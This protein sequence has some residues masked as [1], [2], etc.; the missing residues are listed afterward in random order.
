MKS[1]I[2]F[3]PL[4]FLIVIACDISK[5]Q[6]AQNL[7]ETF[8]TEE[9]KQLEFIEQK[10]HSYLKSQFNCSNEDC[11]NQYL[12]SL[13]P[14]EKTGGLTIEFPKSEYNEILENVNTD[15]LSEIWLDTNIK[16]DR[17][18]TLNPDGKY[19]KFLQDL[20]KSNNAVKEYMQYYNPRIGFSP[21]L[22]GGS[23][24]KFVNE[25]FSNKE[26]RIFS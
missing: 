23:I 3:F 4:L 17:F 8:S 14:F 21:S 19:Y 13:L 26:L 20:G 22:I 1:K 18:L 9:I 6:S 5:N 24:K 16:N 25:D 7:Q 2:L 11:Y 10:Y 15:L 12:T